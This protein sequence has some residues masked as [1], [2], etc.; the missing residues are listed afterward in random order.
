MGKFIILHIKIDKQ[1]MDKMRTIT[2]RQGSGNDALE[3]TVQVTQAE[4]EK[5]EELRSQN[6]EKWPAYSLDL[7]KEAREALAEPAKPQ[8]KNKRKWPWI[9]LTIILAAMSIAIWYFTRNSSVVQG[10][11]LAFKNLN[12]PVKNVYTLEFDA[13]NA[14][15]EGMIIIDKPSID[16]A[17]ILRF[18]QQGNQTSKEK[19]YINSCFLDLYSID[20][21]LGLPIELESY[22]PKDGSIFQRFHYEYDEKGNKTKE[23]GGIVSL[24]ETDPISTYSYQFDDHDR[25]ITMI[26]YHDDGT[27]PTIAKTQYDNL[28]RIIKYVNETPSSSWYSETVDYYY[29]DNGYT[30]ITKSYKGKIVEKNLMYSESEKW[31]FDK[32]NRRNDRLKYKEDG[33]LLNKDS[34]YYNKDSTIYM[35]KTWFSDGKPGSTYNYLNIETPQDDVSFTT[36]LYDAEYK[37]S[38]ISIKIPKGDRFEYKSYSVK[39]DISSSM[40]GQY[41]KPYHRTIQSGKDVLSIEY[42]KNNNPKTSQY[43]YSDGETVNTQFSY[44]GQEKDWK[45]IETFKYEDGK[46]ETTINTYSGYNLLSAIESNGHEEYWEYNEQGEEVSYRE[47]KGGVTISNIKYSDFVNDKY[48]N[49]IRRTNYN[50]LTDTYTVTERCIEYY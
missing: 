36:H 45:R 29:D 43:T 19:I 32:E 33:K 2:I 27:P 20:N 23:I 26:T 3:M 11:D 1:N 28:G 30:Q 41:E 22:S 16:N 4:F 47:L 21:E 18:D 17:T 44:Y 25:V 38:H 24:Y 37:I 15:G 39:S 49:W 12:G 46:K 6:P 9:V 7:I 13:V 40:Y 35:L 48:G 14:F 42:D 5:M 10:N 8:S 31:V 50:V 34:Y